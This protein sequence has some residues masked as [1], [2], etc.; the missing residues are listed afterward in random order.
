MLG[1]L[2]PSGSGTYAINVGAITSHSISSNGVIGAPVDAVSSKTPPT[3]ILDDRRWS[4][5]LGRFGKRKSGRTLDGRTWDGFPT[6]RKVASS[7]LKSQINLPRQEQQFGRK[8][9]RPDTRWPPALMT[10]LP[11]SLRVNRPKQESQ[12]VDDA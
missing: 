8:S 7:T 6:L 2:S 11:I 10:Y 12:C 9:L 5:K 1:H 4:V 3:S